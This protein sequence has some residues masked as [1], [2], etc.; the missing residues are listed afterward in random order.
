MG[1]KGWDGN[2]VTPADILNACGPEQLWLGQVEGGVDDS[3]SKGKLKQTSD[4]FGDFGCTRGSGAGDI[5]Y[6]DFV[7]KEEIAEEVWPFVFVF[8]GHEEDGLAEFSGKFEGQEGAAH[9]GFRR[10]D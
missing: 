1:T 9:G 5:E 3:F 2:T 10:D 7:G 4:H 8:A 6:M